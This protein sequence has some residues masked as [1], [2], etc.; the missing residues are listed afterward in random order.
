MGKLL[1]TKQKS[2]GSVKDY[3][4]RF[5]NLSLL[6]PPGMPLNMLLQSCCHNF[7]TRIENRM[8]AVKAHT[9]KDLVEQAEI[10]EKSA[11]RFDA[12]APKPRWAPDSNRGRDNAQSSQSKGKDTMAVNSAAESQPT[13]KKTNPGNTSGYR[14]PPPQYSFKEEKVATLFELL[15]K[16]NKLK[17]PDPVR[18]EDVG[19]TD[20]PNYCLYH[21]SVHHPTNKCFNLKAK[22]QALIDAG[23]L[24]L[25]PE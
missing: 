3:I 17:L 20:D 9:W 24:V 5:R 21:R 19:R 6:C 15:V 4:E 14:M 10:A 13:P 16:G 1:D 18:P 7:L 22:I 2:Q 23:V 11:S 12:A 8:G 25:K